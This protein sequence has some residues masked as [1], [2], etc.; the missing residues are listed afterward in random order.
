MSEYRHLSYESTDGIGVLTMNRPEVLNSYNLAM[1]AEFHSLFDGLDKDLATRV[2]IIHRCWSW[3]LR[4]HLGIR[5][6]KELLNFSLGSPSLRQVVE[7]ENRTQVL[8]LLTE[9]FEETTR[10]FAA[11]RQPVYEHR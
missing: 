5:M 4:R 7:M 10:A 8:C 3:L 11:R 1:A 2:L 9:D 6:T